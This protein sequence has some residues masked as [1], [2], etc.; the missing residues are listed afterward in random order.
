M[1]Q[2]FTGK[3][4]LKIDIANS[5]GLDKEDWDVRL[6]WFNQNEKQ[7]DTL[8]KSAESPAMYFAGIQA[9]KKASKGEPTGYPISLDATASGIQILACLTGDRR[10]AEL[11]NVI[12]TGT[13]A[14]AYT[15]LYMAMCEKLGEAGQI[16]RDD[17]KKSV[18]T[19]FYG[20]TATPK[21]IFGEGKLL[22]IFYETMTEQAPGAWELNEQFLAMWDPT[23]YSNDWVM[24]DNFHVH[25]KVM[26]TVAENVQF[27]NAPYEVQYSVNQPMENGRS[28]GANCNHSVDGMLVRE[29][30]RRCNYDPRKIANLDE[31]IEDGVYGKET[32][33]ENGKLVSI[34]WDHYLD[35]GF[36][37]ARILNYLDSTN[38]GLVNINVIRFLIETLPAKPFEVI[39]V[40]DC[41]RCLPNY[42]NDL[43]RQYNILLA[44]IAQSNLLSFLVSQM[45]GR[46]V[47]INKIDPDMYKEILDANY[48][49]S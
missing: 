44:E 23:K 29:M 2:T 32:N 3:E 35:S 18:M 16:Q 34:L 25:V 1:M 39:S 11:C 14:D 10:A 41:F 42:G 12:D 8:V 38:L 27:L 28:L 15:H 4:Y 26:A 19:A 47:T 43:R 33:N 49:L 5:F 31:A 7:L 24:P 40:H 21:R 20:S 36:I 45:V 37:S 6:D 22:E 13:R 46:I 30:E 9:W 17:T 48:S